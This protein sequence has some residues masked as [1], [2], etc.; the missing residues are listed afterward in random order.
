MGVL[1]RVFTPLAPPD[2]ERPVHP[3]LPVLVLAVFFIALIALVRFGKPSLSSVIFI[4]VWTLLT[5][6]FGL[7]RGATGFWAALLIV[8]ICAAGLLIDGVASIALAALATLLLLAWDFYKCRDSLSQRM[9]FPIFSNL[10]RRLGPP[11]FGLAF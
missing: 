11:D 7:A 5:T 1:L 9:C 8:P 4:G 6:L 2:T 10:M 3:F